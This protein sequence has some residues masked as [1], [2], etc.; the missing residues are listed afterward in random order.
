MFFIVLLLIVFASSI[1][2]RILR[3]LLSFN[4]ETFYKH[5]LKAQR[6][7]IYTL[8]S[9]RRNWYILSAPTQMEYRDLR[10]IQG[11][12]ATIMFMVIFGHVFYYAEFLPI[13]NPEV[14]EGVSILTNLK[15]IIIFVFNFYIHGSTTQVSQQC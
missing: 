4:G 1:I 13:G 7:Q 15:V 9:I 8:F 12:R 10:Y 6:H 2:D 5:R 14:L 3:N 11:V